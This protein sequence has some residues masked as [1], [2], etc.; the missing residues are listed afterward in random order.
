MAQGMIDRK[1]N[2]EKRTIRAGRHQRKGGLFARFALKF[3][4]LSG[5]CER[6]GDGYLLFG[7][8]SRLTFLSYDGFILIDAACILPRAVWI[9]M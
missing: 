6:H 5:E 7:K 8:E 1:V 9:D 2:P 3:K 4:A